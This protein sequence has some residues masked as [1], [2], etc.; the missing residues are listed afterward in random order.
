VDPALAARASLLLVMTR[1][2]AQATDRL[3]RGS[4]TRVE[5][6]G[7]FDPGPIVQRDIPDPYG[8]SAEVFEQAFD[9][10]D[11]CLLALTKAWDR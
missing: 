9:R 7:D 5:I 11:R 8:E 6:L 10:I 2:Q 1:D 3:V 4:S